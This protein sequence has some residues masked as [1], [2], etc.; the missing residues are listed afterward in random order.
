MTNQ[1][2]KK[3]VF[4]LYEQGKHRRY[5]LL[6]SVNGGA[7]AIGNLFVGD[8]GQDK[9]LGDLKLWMLAVAMMLFSGVMCFDIWMFGEKMKKLSKVLNDPD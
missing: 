4:E 8:H 6:F 9:V 3:D 1:L 5:S 2:T 7:F